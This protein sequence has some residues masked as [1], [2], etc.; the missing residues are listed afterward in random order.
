MTSGGDA[1][2]APVDLEPV[3]GVMEDVDLMTLAVHLETQLLA[4]EAALATAYRVVPRSLADFLESP[5][6]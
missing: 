2:L 4:Y 1:T 3:A 5:A 6:R